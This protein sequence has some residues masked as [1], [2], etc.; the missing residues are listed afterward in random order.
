MFLG[1]HEDLHAA[2]YKCGF[3]SE[4]AKKAGKKVF[5][6]IG[7]KF[8]TRL[9]ELVPEKGFV[10]GKPTPTIADLALYDLVTSK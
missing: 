1:A 5:P 3:G 7:E 8:C 10:L 6:I 2:M 9:E 4:E